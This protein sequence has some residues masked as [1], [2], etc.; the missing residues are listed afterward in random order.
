MLP[1][2]AAGAAGPTGCGNVRSGISWPTNV[3][4]ADSSNRLLLVNS[5]AGAFACVNTI[6][7][8]SFAPRCR[9][10]NRRA[11]FSRA[12]G[13]IGVGIEV[14]QEDHVRAAVDAALVTLDIRLDRGGA[15]NRLA[16]RL[17]RNVHERERRNRLLLAVLEDLEVVL[18]QIPDEVALRVGHPHVHLDDL[19]L[20]PERGILGLGCGARRARLLPGRRGGA[21]KGGGEDD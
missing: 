8:R 14:V 2:W 3:S 20:Q 17:D 4:T 1:T 13:P 5:W 19:D 11:A 18:R 15:G 21:T 7:I 10:M 16:G 12:S 6:A 9:S